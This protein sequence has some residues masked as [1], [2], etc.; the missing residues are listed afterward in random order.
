[1]VT[2][3]R[4]LRSCMIAAFLAPPLTMS[5]DASPKNGA[6]PEFRDGVVLV[7]FQPDAS[8][9]RQSELIDGIGA[10]VKQIGAAVQIG[11]AHV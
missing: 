2:S 7:S 8:E 10:E 5:L 3:S 4:L 9:S 6:A 11:R 1:M